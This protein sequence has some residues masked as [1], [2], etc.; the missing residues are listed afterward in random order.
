MNVEVV[1]TSR[2]TVE[3]RM[4]SNTYLFTREDYA[5]LADAIF[6]NPPADVIWQARITEDMVGDISKENL[7]RMVDELD[8]F[9]AGT[10]MEWDV[11]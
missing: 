5:A 9:V 4:G 1:Y 6:T 10:A 3:I 2:R 8:D 11:A 7:A